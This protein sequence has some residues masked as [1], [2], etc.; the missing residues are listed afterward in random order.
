MK[1]SLRACWRF[2]RE[3]TSDDAYERYVEHHRR[4]HPE[5]P[6]LDRRAFY[7]AEQQ[8]K[9]RGVARCC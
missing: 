6:P 2:I 5:R 4:H 9:W 1:I 3:L 8:R 7:M